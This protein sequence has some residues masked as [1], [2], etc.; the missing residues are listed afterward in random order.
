V[1][2]VAT[3]NQP[4][5]QPPG[6]PPSPPTS[7]AQPKDAES[8]PY[9]GPPPIFPPAAQVNGADA[10]RGG[11]GG[12]DHWPRRHN[13]VNR[14][15]TPNIRRLGL[16][17]HPLADTYHSLLAMSWPRFLLVVLVLYILV[18]TVF[19]AGYYLD[20]KGIE[21]VRPGSLADCFYFSVQ[22]LATIGYG[23]MAP[24]S[25]W[26]HLLVT[27]ES[28]CGLISTALMT[29]LVY[30]KFSRPT[31][32]ILFS[33]VAVISMRDGVPSLQVRISNERGN[34][35]PE[36][37]LSVAIFRSEKTQEGERVRR[38][39]DL[40]LVR[41]RSPVF[42]LSWTAVHQ[43]HP[44]S[45]L[46]GQTPQSLEATNSEILVTFVGLDGT[47]SQ[48]VHARHAYK[49]SD[50]RWNERFVDLFG[51]DARGRTFID[52]RKFHETLPMDA[53]HALPPV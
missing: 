25:T 23:K 31:A 12:L 53:A 39:Y 33:R 37:Q 24:I 40:P 46:F 42:A 8:A 1:V 9:A 34:L 19:A 49:T 48:T 10:Q 2:I 52:Y 18:N 26:A 30:A 22:T 51:H 21:N 15:G 35:I 41:S 20:T 45:P 11:R 17:P 4:P 27:L 50:L 38:F 32:R 29:G 14:D 6:E 3:S 16:R 28:L 43:I 13:L 44:D 47:L 7:G 5:G 36:A